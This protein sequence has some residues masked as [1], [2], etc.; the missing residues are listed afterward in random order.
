M[1]TTP[2]ESIATG[3]LRAPYILAHISYRE[4]KVLFFHL[5]RSAMTK[6][7]SFQPTFEL[8]LYLL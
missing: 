3:L 1:L 8:Q 2:A 7:Y 5:I 4:M 6:F